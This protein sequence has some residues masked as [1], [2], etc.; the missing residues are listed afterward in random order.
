[1]DLKKLHNFMRI[2]ESGSLSRT[3]DRIRVA[4][5]VLSRQMHLLEAEVGVP[6]FTRHRRGMH[7]TEAGQELQRRLSG[8]LRQI[9][10][11]LQDVCTLSTEA[12]GHIAFGMPP[13]VSYLL[14]GRLARR[15]A[16]QAPNVSLRIVEGY[17]GHLV[18]WLQR[19]EVDLAIVYGPAS[20]L[21]MKVEDLVRE[22]LMLVGPPNSKLM[23]T[24]PLN[25]VEMS[26]LPLVLP[27][28]SH[29]LRVIVENAAR[30]VR[31]RFNIRFE[32][33]SF[34]VLK[35]LVESGLG[36]TVLPLSAFNREA[37]AGRLRYAPLQKPPLVRRLVLGTH[38]DDGQSRA[39]RIVRRLVRAEMEELI[40]SKVWQAQLQAAS[41]DK[42]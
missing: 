20:D 15:V 39:T 31:A 9:E 33:D 12:T 16:E 22:Q 21:H 24:Q 19:G 3:A 30:R 23:P 40:R 41:A 35:E 32:A 28:Q 8:P 42:H 17:S 26:K 27:S 18:D 1:M 7:L 14:A 13:T 36:Y 5:P 34:L 10:Q 29:G 37:A 4:Q 38:D 6:L 25:I 2:A 11:A